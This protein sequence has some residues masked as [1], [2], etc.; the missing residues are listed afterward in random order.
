MDDAQLVEVTE[1]LPRAVEPVAARAGEDHRVRHVAQ[2]A[3]DLPGDG[4]V[5]LD[6]ERIVDACLEEQSRGEPTVLADEMVH[7]A[8]AVGSLDHH[9]LT[10][11]VDDLL[12]DEAGHAVRA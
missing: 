4:L 5:A 9:G 10:A 3:H 12:E 8:E 7:E 11:E 1:A 2:I 6:A